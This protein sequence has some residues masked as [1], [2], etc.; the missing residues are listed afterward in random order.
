MYFKFRKENKKI[1]PN[2][3]GPLKPSRTLLT[4]IGRHLNIARA[5]LRSR[6]QEASTPHSSLLPLLF[7]GRRHLPGLPA[8]ERPCS[9]LHLHPARSLSS[10]TSD[11]RRGVE[12]RCGRAAATC[13]RAR[14]AASADRSSAWPTGARP[15]RHAQRAHT[16]GCWR[17]P[18]GGRHA[19]PTSHARRTWLGGSRYG[20]VGL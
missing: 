16:P 10:S 2:Q 14:L 17:W 18:A 12:Q 6:R 15:P 3:I 4:L 7:S 8:A 11:G 1:K 20:L 5:T 19:G 9:S 13:S